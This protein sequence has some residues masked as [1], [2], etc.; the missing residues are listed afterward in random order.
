MDN[1]QCHEKLRAV[2]TMIVQLNAKPLLVYERTEKHIL[3]IDRRKG[4]KVFFFFVEMIRVMLRSIKI[5][6]LEIYVIHTRMITLHIL[7]L[8]SRKD[9]V[10]KKKN[11]NANRASFVAH[12][13][14]CII[15]M[16]C[17]YT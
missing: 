17:I 3:Y 8:F 2:V 5:R 16:S 10:K 14:A 7:Y 1:F 12:N 9:L 4:E 6:P 11:N 13:Y 15:M